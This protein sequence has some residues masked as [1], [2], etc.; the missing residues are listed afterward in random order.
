MSQLPQELVFPLIGKLEINARL[1]ATHFLI[2]LQ[3]DEPIGFLRVPAGSGESIL[4]GL[5]SFYE[6]LEKSRSDGLPRQTSG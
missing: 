6:S 2:Y 3:D 4:A 1:D 5:R